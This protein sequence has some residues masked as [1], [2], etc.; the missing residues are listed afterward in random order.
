MN[1]Y[2]NKTATKPTFFTISVSLI[3]TFF[4]TQKWKHIRGKKSKKTS[5]PTKEKNIRLNLHV[6]LS[7]Q[8]RRIIYTST[9]NPA[10]KN[11][12]IYTPQRQ[13]KE[14]N[15]QFFKGLEGFFT[16]QIKSYNRVTYKKKDRADLLEDAGP[17]PLRPLNNSSESV[18]RE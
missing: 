13:F 9:T 18:E 16:F 7:P 8:W 14:K 10:G 17:A 4:I 6:L 2:C 3:F 1:F 5:D 11:R 15:P 12:N